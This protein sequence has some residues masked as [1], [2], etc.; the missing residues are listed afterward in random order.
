MPCL[1]F[2]PNSPPWSV[3]TTA[4]LRKDYRIHIISTALADIAYHHRDPCHLY[5]LRWHPMS[6]MPVAM[7]R[8]STLT[9][10]LNHMAVHSQP[11]LRR[12]FPSNNIL[13]SLKITPSL[14][15]NPNL[16]LYPLKE[17]EAGKLRISLLQ[18]THL[19]HQHIPSSSLHSKLH[20]Q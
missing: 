16:S 2:T 13:R 12:Q 15:P 20:H 19:S 14:K 10:N 6:Q 17:L 4:C 8:A 1:T 11:I 9:R 3:I 5:I 7:P 18:R